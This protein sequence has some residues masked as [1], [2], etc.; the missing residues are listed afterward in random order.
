MGNFVKLKVYSFAIEIQN[1]GII[2]S[3]EV[4]SLLTVKYLFE[5]AKVNLLTG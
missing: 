3:D 5:L 4:H 1:G 2:Y